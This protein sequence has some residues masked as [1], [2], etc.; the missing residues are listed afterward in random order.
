MKIKLKQLHEINF[1]VN[2]VEPP[3]HDFL[4]WQAMD[5]KYYH[6]KRQ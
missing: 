3:A 5:V 6:F 4:L 2:G 1:I